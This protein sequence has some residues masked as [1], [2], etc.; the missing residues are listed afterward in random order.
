MI[1][2][3]TCVEC[4]TAG[5]PT[6]EFVYR[7][8]HEGGGFCPG[9][10]L[11]IRA[12][13]PR[14]C[15]YCKRERVI[16]KIAPVFKHPAAGVVPAT[17]KVTKEVELGATRSGKPRINFAEAPS[18][19]WLAVLSEMG[20][21]TRGSSTSTSVFF[22][23]KAQVK[24][25]SEGHGAHGDA[26]RL[27]TWNEYLVTIQGPFPVI[28]RIRHDGGRKMEPEWLVFTESDVRVARGDENIGHL[29]DQMDIEEPSL[30][31]M[32]PIWH[33]NPLPHV[34]VIEGQETTDLADDKYGR[35][36]I[37]SRKYSCFYCGKEYGFQRSIWDI[38]DARVNPPGIVDHAV[39]P[40]PRPKVP[41]LKGAGREI[42]GVHDYY[43]RNSDTPSRLV[44]GGETGDLLQEM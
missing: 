24:I 42:F 4:G 44:D 1:E 10:N 28:V 3:L 35:L 27:G 36:V 11:W 12:N 25:V 30:H 8:V 5:T 26:G 2:S 37:T 40:C 9:G 34:P 20:A 38:A 43:V 33:A 17:G 29:C 6:G 14:E 22:K 32:Q 15:A 23:N 21:Y 16:D 41:A 7:A 18:P 39:E 19:G 13:E 31:Q